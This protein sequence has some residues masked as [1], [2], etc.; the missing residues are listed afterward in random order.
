MLPLASSPQEL[1]TVHHKSW[2]T[3]TAVIET[4]H[5]DLLDA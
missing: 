3:V 4:Y 5:R 2:R 1:S